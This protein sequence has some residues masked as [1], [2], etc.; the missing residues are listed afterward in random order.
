MILALPIA[1]AVD[2]K[3]GRRC[4]LLLLGTLL[5]IPA[6]LS[7]G[8]WDLHPVYP[9]IVLG[10]SFA[11]V[12]AVLG[13]TVSLIVEKEVAGT[14]FGLLF[15]VQNIGLA[16][17]P[18]LNGYLRDDTGSYVWSQ[19]MF[20]GLGVIALVF[21]ILLFASDRNKGSVLERR[22]MQKA[23]ASSPAASSSSDSDGA[24]EPRRRS[25]V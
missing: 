21:A 7:M 19:M 8:L 20:V 16:T 18:V 6:H 9:M 17:F 10:V 25:G 2:K 1:W 5:M 3:I 11:L 23:V 13:P 15:M 14:A 12:S 24:D 22:T 4:T